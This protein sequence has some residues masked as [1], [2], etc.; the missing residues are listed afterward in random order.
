MT[1]TDTIREAIEK[2]QVPAWQTWIWVRAEDRFGKPTEQQADYLNS[3]KDL[4][5]LDRIAE[6]VYTATNWDALLRTK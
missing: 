1:F 2:A 6:R 3:L 4:E 5:R